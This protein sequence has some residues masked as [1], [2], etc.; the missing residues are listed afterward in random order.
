M[1]SGGTNTGVMKLV[2]DANYGTNNICIGI[3]TWGVIAKRDALVDKPGAGKMEIIG[4]KTGASKRDDKPL[5]EGQ[6][7]YDYHLQVG[8]HFHF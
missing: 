2:G 7:K 6:R 1:V 5:D 3:A 4:G 8:T